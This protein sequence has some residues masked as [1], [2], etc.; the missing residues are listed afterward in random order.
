[1]N[2]AITN[3]TASKVAGTAATPTV[4]V[5]PPAM[6]DVGCGVADAEGSGTTVASIVGAGADTGAAGTIGAGSA[7][8]ATH[9][10]SASTTRTSNV[11][12]TIMR[13]RSLSDGG[14]ATSTKIGPRTP[15]SCIARARCSQRA[16]LWRRSSLIDSS[17]VVWSEYGVRLRSGLRDDVLQRADGRSP[18]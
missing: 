10:P 4:N 12:L 13:T 3:A 1:M 15:F 6:G 9:A 7:A 11:A 17:T 16:S 2:A 14:T 8:P 18:D 5:D